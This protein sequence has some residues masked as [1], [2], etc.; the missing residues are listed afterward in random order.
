VGARSDSSSEAIRPLAL[1]DSSIVRL[2]VDA[3]PSVIVA[4]AV[5]A[6]TKAGLRAARTQ[7]IP[8]IVAN[9][10]RNWA[11]SSTSV[12]GAAAPGWSVTVGTSYPV[13]NGFQR[14]DAIARADAAAY[15]ARIIASDTHRSVRASAAQ[16]LGAIHTTTASISLGEDAIRSAR[17]DLR[18]Q[19][20][21]YRAG[22]STIL[23]VLT[24][25]A[26]LLSAEYSLAQSRNRYH[27]TRSALEALVGRTL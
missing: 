11:A 7:Y 18:V 1:D 17:E 9:G 20:V 23:D 25:Q 3:S 10:V 2:A 4:N 14:E 19:T 21:R 13:F 12:P 27:I 5:A 15:V 26:A 6:A 24:S 16:L 8:T 22:I